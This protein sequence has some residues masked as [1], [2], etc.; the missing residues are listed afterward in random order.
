MQKNFSLP[1]IF[2]NAWITISCCFFFSNSHARPQEFQKGTMIR[3]AEIE[4]FIKDCLSPLLE[5]ARISIDSVKFHL[6][7]DSDL[8][9][10]TGPDFQLF[11]NSG[12]FEHS[13]TPEEFIGVLAHEIGHMVNGDVALR[14]SHI[15]EMSTPLMVA[16]ILGAAAGALAGSGEAAAG[17]LAGTMGVGQGHLMGYAR[18][19]ESLADRTAVH[20]LEKISWP[21]EGFVKTLTTLKRQESLTTT[22]QDLYQRTHPFAQSRLQ[23]MKEHAKKQENVGLPSSLTKRFERVK[24]KL[25]AFLNNAGF[26]NQKY[27]GNSFID[28]YAQIISLWRIGSKDISLQKLNS[29]L[30]RHPDDA[31]LWELKGQILFEEGDLQNALFSHMKAHTLSQK[32]PLFHLNV[33]QTL[34]ELQDNKESHT[35]KALALLKEAQELDPKNPF[36]WQLLSVAY[37]RLG[38]KGEMA[39][40]LAEKAYLLGQTDQVEF[41][42]KRAIALLPGGSPLQNRAQDL[43]KTLN[44]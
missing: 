11:I 27:S 5:A 35:R 1:L 36:V 8:N 4:S 37:G 22:Q 2:L 19:Q 9:A 28:Q 20:L 26:I 18:S 12:L 24:A 43:I 10:A 44:N 32:E 38:L 13:Q 21:I 3:D 15:Q 33:A 25:L 41:Q 40:S 7:T 6:I 29:L 39:L 16:G 23:M 30:T 34:L 17:I 42:G 14:Q 31:Y